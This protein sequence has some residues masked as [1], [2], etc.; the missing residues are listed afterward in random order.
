MANIFNI[1]AI[2]TN[3][4]PITQQF[5]LSLHAPDE[6][7]NRTSAI[8]NALNRWSEDRHYG[9]VVAVYVNTCDDGESVTWE[10]DSVSQAV[11]WFSDGHCDRFVSR[12]WTN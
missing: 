10:F 9:G 1:T 4:S 5:N 2:R 6:I 11:S 12:M 3:G 7:L 8:V